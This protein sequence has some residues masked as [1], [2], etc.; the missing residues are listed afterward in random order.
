MSTLR[1]NL[2]RRG[3]AKNNRGVK[4]L[5]SRTFAL[6]TNGTLPKGLLNAFEH[7]VSQKPSKSF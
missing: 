4:G 2:R 3:A 5:A 7:V 1:G 6:Y